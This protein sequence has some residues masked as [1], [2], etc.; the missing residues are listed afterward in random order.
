MGKKATNAEIQHRV[1]TVARLLI[2]CVPRSQIISH[3]REAWGVKAEMIDQYI[4]R[5]RELVRQDY[6]V[7]RKDFVATRLGTLDKVVQ[8]GLKTNQLGV[9]V[10]A[11]KLQADLT[12]ISK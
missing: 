6:E 7:E 11:L 8:E 2:N 9:V 3:G 1:Q 5:A 12:Q 4:S 10:G